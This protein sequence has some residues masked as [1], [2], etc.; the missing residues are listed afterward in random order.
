[1]TR[2]IDADTLP[3]LP[4][5]AVLLVVGAVVA[6][7]IIVSGLLLLLRPTMAEPRPVVLSVYCASSAAWMAT[8]APFLDAQAPTDGAPERGRVTS[9]RI[10]SAYERRCTTPD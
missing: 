4:K 6:I 10:K 3:R 2:Q 7:G 8:L 1:M 5:S 9:A